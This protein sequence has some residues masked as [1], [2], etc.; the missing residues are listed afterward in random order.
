MELNVSRGNILISGF[1]ATEVKVVGK[2][3]ELTKPKKFMGFFI[4]LRGKKLPK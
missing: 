4:S 2:F 1:K 3:S